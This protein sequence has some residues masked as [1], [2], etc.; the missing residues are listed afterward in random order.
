M[1]S[2]SLH[3]C[4]RRY[5]EWPLLLILLLWVP[6]A[7]AQSS[8]E[9]LFDQA[10]EAMEQQQFMKAIDQYEGILEQGNTSGALHLNMAFCYVKID[11]LG[12]AKYHLLKAE[13]FDETRTQAQESLTWLQDQFSRNSAVLPPLPWEEFISYINQRWTAEAVLGLGFILLNLAAALWVLYW[14][15]LRDQKYLKQILI[16]FSVL[17]VLTTVLGFYAEY[18]AHRYSTAVMV[19]QEAVLREQPNTDAPPVTKAYE[20]YTFR[21]DRNKS[22]KSDQTHW[23][24]VRMSNGVYG[25][26]PKTDI[27]I[28]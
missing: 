10:N 7:H 5:F 28:L 12:K 4:F 8:A 16:G 23:M 21:V 27:L 15:R 26:I 9:L 2:S 18:V 20:G 1:G 14:L 6:V 19:H 24:Y 13:R 22:Q 3:T 11:S 17:A 25:W